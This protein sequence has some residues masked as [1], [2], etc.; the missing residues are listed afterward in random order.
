MRLLVH[1]HQQGADAVLGQNTGT[2]YEELHF[3]A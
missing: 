2:L 1:G 3:V